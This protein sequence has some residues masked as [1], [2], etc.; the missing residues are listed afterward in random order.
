[1]LGTEELGR[2]LRMEK[3]R[4]ERLNF[5]PFQKPIE[6]PQDISAKCVQPRCN[7]RIME[8]D[9]IATASSHISASGA[10]SNIFAK[11]LKAGLDDINAANVLT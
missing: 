3:R 9:P 7:R 10:R 5:V 6:F 2:H 1:M 11:S 4:V 8:Y